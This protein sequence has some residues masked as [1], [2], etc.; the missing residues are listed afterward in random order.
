MGSLCI[1]RQMR[2]L[3]MTPDASRVRWVPTCCGEC[4]A[5]DKDRLLC[6]RHPTRAHDS[7]HTT[8][9]PPTG[10]DPHSA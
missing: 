3:R 1:H 2:T 7:T 6:P 4:S 10:N 5:W 8:N 9:A